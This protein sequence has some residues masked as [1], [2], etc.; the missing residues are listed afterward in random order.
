MVLAAMSRFRVGL[1]SLLL[2]LVGAAPAGAQSAG[3]GLYEPFPE[4]A[5]RARAERF[6]GKLDARAPGR[7]SDADLGRGSFTQA[8]PEPS[9]GR[10]A[11]ARAGGAGD[12]APASVWLVVAAL[13]AACTAPALRAAV[14]RRA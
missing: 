10:P 4:V 3:N 1:A 13:V 14:S 2:C 5:P 6:V 7:A 9:G 8:L 11:S 12:L